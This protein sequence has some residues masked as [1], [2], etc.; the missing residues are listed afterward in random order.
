[1]IRPTEAGVEVDVHVI[2]RSRQNEIDGVRGDA[3]LVRL[4][5]PPVDEAA[6]NALVELMAAT[7]NVSRRAVRIVGGE[8]ARRKRVAIDGISPQLAALRLGT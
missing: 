5:A 1:M 7:L 6:N 4:T 3:V 8:H 2:P